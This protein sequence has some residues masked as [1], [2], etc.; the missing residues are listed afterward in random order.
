MVDLMVGIEYNPSVPP[1]PPPYPISFFSPQYPCFFQ[2]DVS[3]LNIV[4]LN[5]HNSVIQSHYLF[6]NIRVL[7][8]LSAATQ[9]C[10]R[11]LRIALYS[12]GC[13]RP[14]E[15]WHVIL[16]IL[17]FN[18]LSIV[19]ATTVFPSYDTQYIRHWFC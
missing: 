19:E 1:S 2:T 9:W 13:C 14:T 12:H 8:I 11:R 3:S 16:H 17:T 6:S 7:P 4:L 15:L 18:F 10:Y 5:I